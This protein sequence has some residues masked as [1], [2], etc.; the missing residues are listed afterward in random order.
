VVGGGALKASS[1]GLKQQ[2]IQLAAG[3]LEVSVEDLAYTDGGVEVVGVPDRRL[4][5]AQIA[6]AAPGG[7]RQDG[8]FG[9]QGDAVPFGATVAVVSIDRETG[10]VTL[11]RLV[12]VDDCG[13]VVNPLIVHG[14]VSGG[15]A[16]GVGEALY[17]QMVFSE[18]G[19]L[20]TG[21][22]LEYAVPRA[23]M[24]PDWELD[25]VNTPST[26]NPLG[27]KGVG[28]SGCVSAPPAV[29]NAVLDALAPLGFDPL[30]MELDMPLTSE[31]V[32]R[33]IQA[34]E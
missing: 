26:T 16:Q 18:D 21:S 12:V 27:A 23:D 33:V 15:L 11:E 6:A 5:L 13:T 9:G 3:M 31:K 2:A 20:L 29:V 19:Q 25:M 8:T 1:E 34:L 28:E 4:S 22:L 14:Q 7:L 17:E 32:W 30:T 24:L 10:R